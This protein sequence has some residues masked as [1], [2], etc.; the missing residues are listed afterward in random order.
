MMM[1]IIGFVVAWFVLGAFFYV[2]D[3]AGGWSIWNTAWDTIL[4][5]LPA[6]PIILLIEFLQEKFKKR[7]PP[8]EE[9]D[10]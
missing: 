10:F 4:M 9:E 5:M 3:S 7:P 2:R 8:E 6:I 1:F